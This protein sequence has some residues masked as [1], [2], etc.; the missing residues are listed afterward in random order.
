MKDAP[1][2]PSS[3][4]TEPSAE[5]PS[6][7]DGRKR[8]SSNHEAVPASL[9]NSETPLFCFSID[10]LRHNFPHLLEF[11]SPLV[12]WVVPVTYFYNDE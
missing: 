1:V 2:L 12:L 4:S 11:L 6:P 9:P 3:Y 10:L 7:P 8:R 5:Q